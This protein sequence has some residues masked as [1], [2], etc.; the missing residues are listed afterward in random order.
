MT[1]VGITVGKFMPLHKGHE[2]MIEFGAAMLDELWVFVS[3]KHTDT[4]PVSLRYHWVSRYVMQKGLHNV[5]VLQHTDRSPTPINIDENGTVLDADFQQYWVNEFR[6]LVPRATHFVSSDLYGKTMAELLNIKWLPV[7]PKREMV[8]ISA[9]EIRKDP[10]AHFSMIS[11][12]AKSHY[13]RKI[14]IVGPESS[15]KST[16]TKKLADYFSGTIVNEY[17]R[18]L[19]EVKGNNMSKEDFLDIMNGQQALI[20]IA[21]SK[22]TSPFIFIDTEAYTT[23]LFSKIYLGEYMEEIRSFGT[24]QQDIDYYI[25]LSPNVDWVDDGTRVLVDQQKREQFFEELVQLLQKHNKSFDVVESSDFSER[26][27]DCAA[28]IQKGIPPTL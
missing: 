17:G 14:A 18:T 27:W 7:D 2:L 10:I 3:G 4:I 28:L 8:S 9:T 16:M 22:A 23:Y 12:A 26:F 20:N 21:V 6:T 13:V 5:K 11:D 1:K 15:G 25:V 24:L 19:S